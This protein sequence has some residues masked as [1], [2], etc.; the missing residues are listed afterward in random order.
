M[1]P[2][3]Q[4]EKKHT[5]IAL[6]YFLLV[7]L[8]GVFLR[9]FYVLPIPAN[10]RFIVHAHS[11]V[12]LLGWVYIALITLIYKLYLSQL[13]KSH[14]YKRIIWFTNICILGM[15][16]S[17]PFQGYAIFSIIFST[18][19]LVSTYLFARFVFSNIPKKYKN[20]P[21]YHCIR[22][23]LWYMVFSSIGPWA[24]GGI[25]ATLGKGSI[26]YNLAIYFYL[27]FQYNGWFIL[28]LI[29]VLFFLIEL[30]PVK[31]D[32]K[33]FRI[34]FLLIHPAIIL[35][36]FLSVLW[37]NPPKIFYFLA[38]I[39]AVL[40]IAAFFYFFKI[41]KQIWTVLRKNIS[42]IALKLLKLSAVFLAIKIALQLISA[43]PYFAK[44]AFLYRD[45]VIGYLHWTF[46]GVVSLCLFG[47]LEHF[48]LIRL[49][50]L[51]LG[52]YLIGFI[53]SELFIFYKATVLWQKLP[54]F[55]P[56]PFILIGTS[57]LIPIAV[58]GLI[59]RSLFKEKF[60]PR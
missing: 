24:V 18:L 31:I 20:S 4:L 42:T 17:F 53:G 29:G 52:I 21:S 51:I 55:S 10:Y 40:Q 14:Y 45:F 22:T 41:V 32:G 47:L 11:H 50:W 2:F 38:A 12:A 19:F 5:N 59:F 34:F 25:M 35:S 8:M 44:L 30:L 33:Q 9:L 6:T 36:F 58:G 57:S 26:W 48:K 7:G 49:N 3:V 43:L 60:H 39:G 13:N 16:F 56:G 28:A 46:L 27:H 1:Y 37:T 15:M 54:A 23:S